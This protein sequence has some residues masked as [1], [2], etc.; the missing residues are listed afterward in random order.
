MCQP[1]SSIAHISSWI[2][3]TASRVTR[4][5]LC[6]FLLAFLVT[7][8]MVLVVSSRTLPN[9]FN[10]TITRAR[11]LLHVV[12]SK[13]ASAHSGI[14]HIESFVSYCTAIESMGTSPY[15]TSLASDE[16][17]GP[18]ERPLYEALVAKGLN[19]IPQH[20]VNQYR[21][22]LAIVHGN[23][24]VD[25]EVDGESTHVDP[26][27]DAE[28]DSRLENLGWR[29]VRFWNRQV[30]DD[31]DYCVQTILELLEQPSPRTPPPLLRQAPCACP[32]LPSSRPPRAGIHP[33]RRGRSSC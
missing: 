31:I 13:S 32:P 26:R 11:S 18:W 3:P 1:T 23:M 14:P 33:R 15:E 16:R 9:L 10:V 7:Y 2:L 29:V 30:R 12:G 19:P 24:R 6:I 17:I 21:L 4:G 20:S 22:D 27:L 5:T 8:L 28:R 25:I